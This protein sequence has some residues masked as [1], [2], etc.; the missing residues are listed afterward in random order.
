MTDA[1]AALDPDRSAL[2]A[3]QHALACDG[4]LQ[5]HQADRRRLAVLFLPVFLTQV[6]I[7]PTLSLRVLKARAAHRLSF[8]WDS[9]ERKGKIRGRKRRLHRADAV[10]RGGQAA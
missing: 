2:C 10:P 7:K 5:R 8:N 9:N 6:A 1:V 4:V 3:V